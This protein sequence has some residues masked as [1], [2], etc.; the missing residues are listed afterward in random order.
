MTVLVTG[1]TGTVG[2][3][4]VQHLLRRGA[5]VRALTRDPARAALPAGVEVVA[6]DLTDLA[7]LRPAVDGVT[8][9]H[10]ITFG[11]DYRPL[12]NGRELVDLIAAA[13]VRKAVVLGGW[14]EGVLEP[15]VRQ[16]ALE[17]TM[18]NPVQFMAN[19][20]TDWA[21]PLRTRGV[22]REP[23]GDRKSPP[24]HE[25]D[26]GEVAAAVLTGDGHGGRSYH[27]TG[28][29]VLT[30]RL[31][32]RALAEAT[33]RAPS[34]GGRPSTRATSGADLRRRVTAPCASPRA[35]SPWPRRRRG[36]GCRAARRC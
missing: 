19:F 3:H 21:G 30:P 5:R 23:F 20:L 12:A 6:G 17:W 22:V 9:V 24:I 31:M 8:A 10:L 1:A 35:P 32:I 18:L 28:P 27:L 34:P 25:E 36:P 26:I 11:G 4:V 13:G 15:A 7:T 14:Q 33:R 2:R 16:S 29:E